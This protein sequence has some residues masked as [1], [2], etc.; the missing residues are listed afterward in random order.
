MAR[1]RMVTRTI[2][3]TTVSVLGINT[4]TAEPFNDEYNIAGTYKDDKKLLKA[5][6]SAYDTESTQIVKIR[7]SYVK[8]TIYGMSEQKFM[9]LADILDDKRHVISED[10]EA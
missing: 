3:S 10:A 2:Q 7:D 5:V 1:K 6:K 9:E 8:D 4:D